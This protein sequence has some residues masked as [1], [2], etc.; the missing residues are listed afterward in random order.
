MCSLFLV[1][2]PSSEVDVLQAVRVADTEHVVLGSSIT[3]PTRPHLGPAAENVAVEGLSKGR[4][5]VWTIWRPT[6]EA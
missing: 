5:M 1:P 3:V 2:R 6:R 4:G